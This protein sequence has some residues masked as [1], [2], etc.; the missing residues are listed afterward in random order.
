L[1]ETSRP[2]SL[3]RATTYSARA[4]RPVHHDPG[5]TVTE[6]TLAWLES[7]TGALAAFAVI[8]VSA[9]D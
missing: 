6:Q 8:S 3:R 7:R 9:D 2:A 5:T 4:A 1:L